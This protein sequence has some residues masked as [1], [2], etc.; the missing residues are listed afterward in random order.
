MKLCVHF[1]INKTILLIDSSIGRG[2]EASLNSLLSECSWGTF[3]LDIPKQVRKE[4]DWVP[5]SFN[6]GGPPPF[7]EAV[8][9]GAYLEDYTC[10]TKAERRK[11]KCEFTE[12][13]RFGNSFKPCLET[14]LDSL[15]IPSH[16]DTSHHNFLSTG[17]YHILPSFFELVNFLVDQDD[18]D[19]RIVF[20]TFGQDTTVIA[21]EFNLF[22][23]NKHPLFKCSRK[24]DGS[25]PGFPKD[26]RLHLPLQSAMFK[27]T[28]HQST[29]L[30]LAYNSPHHN[31]SR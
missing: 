14:L 29:G 8:S 31:V 26:F 15:R 2:F 10:L 1:D 6:V 7:D 21:E 30:H 24:L 11:F 20:R 13:S 27:R 3:P 22:C 19:F 17:Y 18:V 23:E 16:V 5:I 4:D 9:Y 28:S 12:N 25:D